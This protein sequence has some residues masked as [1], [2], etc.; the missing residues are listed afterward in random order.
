MPLYKLET[1][2]AEPN[3]RASQVEIYD[4]LVASSQNRWPSLLFDL[5]AVTICSEDLSRLAFTTKLLCGH[6]SGG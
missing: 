4:G 6:A 2:Y 3:V 1:E 5:G